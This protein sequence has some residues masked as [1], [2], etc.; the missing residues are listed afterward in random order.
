VLH[1][2]QSAGI[3]GSHGTSPV[4]MSHPSLRASTPIACHRH[5][6]RAPPGRHSQQGSVWRAAAFGSRFSAKYPKKIGYCS[7][8]FCI[9]VLW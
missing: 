5:I 1:A 8:G 9:S 7:L 2:P 4:S 6:F 3:D